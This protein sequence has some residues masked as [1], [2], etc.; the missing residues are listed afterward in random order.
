MRIIA[1]K[2]KGRRL[3][4]ISNEKTRP[5]ADAVKEGLFSKIQFDI[6]NCSFL[7]LFAG[8]GSIGIEAL[9]RGAKEVVFVEKDRKNYQIIQN[10]INILY[11]NNEKEESIL[12]L[13]CDYISALNQLNHPFDFVYIDP[14]YKSKFYEPAMNLLREK[15]LLISKSM[16]ICEHESKTALEFEGYELLITK[17]YG[18]KSLSYFRLK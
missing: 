1:G 6:P 2:F 15:G 11:K 4:F 18:I 7:D 16:V 9:S 3:D 10:N 17:R 13:P 14:P 5:T 8:S 12:M